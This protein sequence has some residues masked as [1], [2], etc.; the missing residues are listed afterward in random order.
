MALVVLPVDKESA[1]ELV[2]R[3]PESLVL[4]VPLLVIVPVA[5]NV[6]V[7]AAP[8]V[9]AIA[10]LEEIVKSPL[11]S[12]VTFEVAKAADTA[13][14]VE[15]SITMFSGSKSQEPAL[16][17]LAETSTIVDLRISKTPEELVSTNPPL[18]PNDPPSALKVPATVVL[19]DD[20]TLMSPP[21]PLLVD[22]TS[23]D[24]FSVTVTVLARFSA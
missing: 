5:F 16:P 21:L 4:I 7:V 14:A 8:L 2:T 22:E 10:A 9:G 3:L 11:T 17:N 24:A 23:M 6:S 15:A 13:D 18:P 1:A 19:T 20:Q 12:M